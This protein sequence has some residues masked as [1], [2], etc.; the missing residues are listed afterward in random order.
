M[1][2]QG[3]TLEELAREVMRQQDTKRDY[4]A[5]TRDM[6]LTPI[7]RAAGECD[8]ALRLGDDLVLGVNPLAH[9]QISA[10][11]EIPRAY[12]N[13]MLAESPALLVRNVNHWFHAEP[14]PR[15]VRTLDGASRAFLSNAY[16]PL[17]NADL[18]EAVLPR[19]PEMNVEVLSCEVTDR[20]LYLKIVDA[21]IKKD[22]PAGVGLGEGH[23]RFRTVSPAAVLSNSEV[24]AGTLQL[25]TSVWEGGCSNLMV[26]SERSVRKYHM[27]ARAD[28]GDEVYRL[29]S[30]STRRLTDAALWAQL[31]DVFGAAFDRAKFD[32]QCER[33]AAATQDEIKPDADPVKVVELTAKKFGLSDGERGSVLQ[34]LIRGGDLSRYG[35]QAAVTRASQDVDGYDRASQLE[36]LGGKI[37]EL[38]R[39]EWAELAKA[40]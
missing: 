34:H 32:A 25:Q 39:N 33:L 14:K 2:K 10:H 20:R 28:I 31:G 4:V 22:L 18:L 9:E 24:G 37:I 29:L 13:R 17:D 38:P 26:I 36:E 1:P 11:T 30:D 21:N 19:L 5:S 8:V 7:E 35:L 15:M 23:T 40:A 16:R 12:Y 3:R 27:G 6:T